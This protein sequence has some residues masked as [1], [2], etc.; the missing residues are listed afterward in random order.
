MTKGICSV[1]VC[2]VFLLLIG[3]QLAADDYQDLSLAIRQRNLAAV[4]ELVNKNPA[5]VK[6]KEENGFTALHIAATAGRVDIIEFLLS[7]GADL[8]GRTAGGQTPL[9]QTVPLAARDA[10]LYLLSRGADINLRDNDGRSILQFALNW[11]RPVMIETIL[12]HGFRLEAGGPDAREMLEQAANSGLA[13]LVDILLAKGVPAGPG[14]HGGTTLLHCA[15]RGGLVE[16]ARLLLK[17]GARL[18]Q[19]DLHTLTPLH[20]AAFYGREDFIHWLLAAGANREARAGDGRTPLQMAEYGGHPQAAA[21]L[22]EKMTVRPPDRFPALSGP[23]PGQPDPGL[24]PRLF[25]PG[26]ISS[27]EHETNI[28]FTPDGR[29]LCFSRINAAQTRRWLLVM[30]LAASGWTPPRPVPFASSGADF[31][32]CYSTDGKQLFFSSN[33]PLETGGPSS[34]DMDI[35]VVERSA[36]GWGE[37]RN[38]GPA[39]NSRSNEYM[40]AVDREENL[41]FERYGLNLAA[42]R[43]GQYQPA[44]KI[45]GGIRNVNNCGHPYITPDGGCLLYD[46]RLPG[47]ARGLLFASFRQPDGSWQQ[48]R[49]LFPGADTREYESCP[50]LSPDGKYLFFGRDHDI[51]WVS[52]AVLEKLKSAK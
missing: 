35:W 27:E 41:Y 36:G 15:A 50:S 51:Y 31:E 12:G 2:L 28:T 6:F 47:S 21:L 48:A 24:E 4:R 38:P 33:R 52:A 16:F 23:Y 39:V 17:N 20:L 8:E 32:G 14:L 30:D 25:A 37:P 5:L 11:Q 49:Q 40:P 45:D 7:Q 29:E 22:A 44:V 46:A 26:L 1:T 3:G 10:F 18:D 34:R 43:D 13:G 9:F 42:W 19:P